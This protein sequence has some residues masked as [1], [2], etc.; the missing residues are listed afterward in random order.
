MLFSSTIF[1]FVFLPL[2]TGVYYACP[3]SWRNRWLL[4]TSLFFY[5]WGEP[6]YLLVMLVSIALN[7]AGA[8]WLASIPDVRKRRRQV[9]L[10]AVC[11][12]NLAIL[13]Y[14]KYLNFLV[15]NINA[16]LNWHLKTADVWM[17]IGIS[18]FTFQSLSYVVDV[19]RREVEAQR[20]LGKTALFISF[21]PQLIAGPILKYHDICRQIDARSETA[22]DVAAGLRRFV[23]G[24]GKK[25]LLANPMGAVANP[26]FS[27]GALD[28]PVAWL[29]AVA[30][31]LQLY[32][33]FSGYSDMAIGLGRMF[34]FRIQENF[35]YPYVSKSIG[36]FWRRWHIS[37]GSWFREYLYYPLGGN[38]KGKGRTLFNLLA[39]F[40]ATGIWHGA[41][42]T[43]LVWGLWHG[44]FIAAERLFGFSATGG[45]FKSAILHLYV[46]TVFGVGWILFR[47][48]SLGQAGKYFAAMFGFAGEAAVP[49]SAEYFLTRKALLTMGVA[50]LAA[51]PIFRAAW[52]RAAGVPGMGLARDAYLL[53]VL[54]LSMLSIASGTYNPFI[55]FRF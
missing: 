23:A 43:F 9:A 16:A 55:Y 2:A 47:C 42:W 15:E 27:M 21:F 30:Y 8:L 17:P 52:G 5:A 39:V 7:H 22:G 49:F 24:L 3:S 26:I 20:S 19:Y 40:T 34:G 18:F 50:M 51:T 4:G 46:V 29:G 13:V 53:A 45:R 37:L 35:N 11:G 48:D 41:N 25:V 38:R 36:E 12:L 28:A 32:F 1:L 14:F 31:A 10:G 33:D 44:L 54:F 6:R